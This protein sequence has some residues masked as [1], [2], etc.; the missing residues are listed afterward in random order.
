MKI[1][2]EESATGR[3]KAYGGALTILFVDKNHVLEIVCF[4]V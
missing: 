3:L 1:E 2:F 4:F